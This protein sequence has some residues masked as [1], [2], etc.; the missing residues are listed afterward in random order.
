MYIFPVWKNLYTH[1]YKYIYI[2]IYV[3]I[4]KELNIQ[5]VKYLYGSLVNL[6]VSFRCTGKVWRNL[7][8]PSQRANE[9]LFLSSSKLKSH[10]EGKLNSVQQIFVIQILVFTK[11]L[12]KS[13]WQLEEAANECN[14]NPRISH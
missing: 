2:C 10:F 3:Y 1:I 14:K 13:C 5:S 11:S 9:C 8:S 4:V 6:A 12:T 7:K